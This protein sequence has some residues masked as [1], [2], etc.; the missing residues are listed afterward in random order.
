MGTIAPIDDPLVDQISIAVEIEGVG[1]CFAYGEW[2]SDLNGVGWK[3][4]TAE[5]DFGDGPAAGELDF[6]FG[7]SPRVDGCGMQAI[8]GP[9]SIDG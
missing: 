3:Q 7:N 2:P 5:D 9:D 6:E 1:G 8:A 4:V